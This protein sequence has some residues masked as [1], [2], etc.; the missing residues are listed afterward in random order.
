VRGAL[1]N[2]LDRFSRSVVGRAH[3]PDSALYKAAEVKHILEIQKDRHG[4][5]QKVFHHFRAGRKMSVAV[6]FDNLDRRNEPIQ[7]EAFLRAS[8]IARDCAALVFVCLRPATFYRSKKVG[9]LDSVAPKIINIV[10][11]KT[12]AMVV[13]RLQFARRIALGEV[14]MKVLFGAKFSAELPRTATFLECVA[15]SFQ[16]SRKLSNLFDLVSNGNAR[17]L[18][19]YVAQ[20]LTSQHL[21]TKKILERYRGPGSYVLGDHEAL[22]ALLYGDYRQYDPRVSQFINLFDIQRADVSEHFTKF[23]ALD[24]LRRVPDG[25]PNYGFTPV[26]LVLRSLYQLGFSEECA[27]EALR[28]LFAQRCCEARVP[29]ET[30]DNAVEEI[31][32]TP[33]GKYHV[34]DLVK[35]FVYMDAVTVDTPIL[36]DRLRAKI[37]DVDDIHHRLE[38]CERFL[39]Y[40]RECSNEIRDVEFQQ[41]WSETSSSVANN[42]REI[43]DSL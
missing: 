37:I 28:L 14:P 13:K 42:I 26:D 12:H 20:V 43:Y 17:D 10:S 6:F 27:K 19:I 9:V 18:L 15:D 21:N 32:I 7:E 5:L 11:P 22:R 1:H 16:R 41:A 3:K 2:D 36:N 4:F 31:R 30:W 40:L 24:H 34:G 23:V 33:H 8:A 25:H 38:R 39:E 35:T 29:V